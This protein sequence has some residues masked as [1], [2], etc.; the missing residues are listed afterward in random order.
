MRQKVFS[1]NIIIIGI[2]LTAVFLSRQP[3]F[4]Q[5]GSF[6]IARGQQI[7]AEYQ[8]KLSD[9]FKA[10]I[11][12]SLSSEAEKRGGMLAEEAQKQKDNVLKRI[13]NKI[14]NYFSGKVYE[15]FGTEVE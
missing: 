4:I 11:Y 1:K 7:G 14:R 12:P 10:G 5:K 3:Y 15:T 13:W 2:I 9:W 6:W 8:Q